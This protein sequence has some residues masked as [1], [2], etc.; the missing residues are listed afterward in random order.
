MRQSVYLLQLV[1]EY[2]YFPPKK[3]LEAEEEEK[4]F[5]EKST[6][7]RHKNSLRG[8]KREKNAFSHH[9]KVDQGSPPQPP[10]IFSRETI[11]YHQ[12]QGFLSNFKSPVEYDWQTLPQASHMV[13]EEMGFRVF[14]NEKSQFQF[15]SLQAC[16]SPASSSQPG[17]SGRERGKGGDTHISLKTQARASRKENQ[18]WWSLGTG[19]LPCGWKENTRFSLLPGWQLPWI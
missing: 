16:W 17:L 4:S 2:H 6:L 9:Q 8:E 5:R 10:P 1:P 12:M 14:K 19:S 13:P 18:A 11:I 15:C 7:R 3:S